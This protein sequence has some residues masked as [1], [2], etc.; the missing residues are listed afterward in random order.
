MEKPKI[1]VLVDADNISHTW[2]DMIIDKA[3]SRGEIIIR[4]ACGTKKH[5]GGRWR[6]KMEEHKFTEKKAPDI[7]NST[8]ML[9]VREV[10]D[11]M[12]KHPKIKIFCLVSNDNHFAKVLQILR[13]WNKKVLIMGTV[14]AA[15]VLQS[16]SEFILIEKEVITKPK[17][18]RK[19]A[20]KLKPIAEF[21][22]LLEQAFKNVNQEWISLNTLGKT[23]KNI[24]A[25]YK[26]QIYGSSTLTKLLK[27]LPK[28]VE[29]KDGKVKLKSWKPYSPKPIAEFQI[30]L[31]KAFK[32]VNQ[33]SIPLKAL[34]DI[35]KGIDSGYKPQIY[36]SSTL[37]KLLKKLPTIVLV[38]GKASIK[39][40]KV[41]KQKQTQKSKKPSKKNHD[42][43]YKEE[44]TFT[45]LGSPYEKPET[46]TLLG[47]NN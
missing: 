13:Q 17:P 12:L 30:L 26:P 23:L 46:F 29:V 1:A 33:E 16:D 15:K 38:G 31:D 44:E 47:K 42:S 34:G 3:S 21:Q 25:T 41:K 37:S 11:I 45:L 43:S 5:L 27:K 9:I 36:G 6:K 28:A 22:I 14:K 24:D 8:D 10:M 7:E 32:S 40:Q 35:L 20:K 39:K 19:K 18:P 2:A 4:Y